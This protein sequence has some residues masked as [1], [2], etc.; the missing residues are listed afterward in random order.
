MD[1]NEVMKRMEEHY[2]EALTLYPKN[3]IVALVLHGSQNYGLDTS[4]SDVDTKLI[5]VPLLREIALNKQPVS[6]THVRANNEHIDIKDVRIYFN[7]LKK[8][9]INYVETLFTKYQI[10]NPLYAD[11]WNA[12]MSIK[13]GIA[14]YDVDTTIKG[15]VGSAL[16][17]YKALEKVTDAKAEKVEKFGYDP[18]ELCHIVRYEHFL[19][20]YIEYAPYEYCLLESHR[21]EDLMAIKKGELSLEK[22]RERAERSID[23][24]NALRDFFEETDKGTITRDVF[25]EKKLENI[26]Y[27]IIKTSLEKDI[28][29]VIHAKWVPYEFGDVRWHKCSNC[30]K[31]MEYQ[32]RYKSFDGKTHLIASVQNYCANCGAKMEVE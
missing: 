22:A 2:A 32:S 31:A 29:P 30:N 24:I 4:E 19:K 27:D 5:V 16:Q 14:R 10:V 25:I 6:R 12:L 15:I 11:F 23:K 18:K 17:K 8:Q 13:S 21:K 9:N 3:R 28:A 7:C 26:L 20:D 1:Y